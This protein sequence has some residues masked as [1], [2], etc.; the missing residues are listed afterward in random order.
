VLAFRYEG[1]TQSYEFFLRDFN[2]YVAICHI[3]DAWKKSGKSFVL[4]EQFSRDYIRDQVRS[5]PQNYQL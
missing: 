5:Y 2:S 4:K 3:I 1:K